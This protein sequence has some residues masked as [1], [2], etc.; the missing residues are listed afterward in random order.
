MEGIKYELLTTV[1]INAVNE[2]QEQLER[3]RRLIEELQSAVAR[4]EASKP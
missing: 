3:Q 2:Q 1:L 4:L